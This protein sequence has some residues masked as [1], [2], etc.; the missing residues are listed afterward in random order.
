[1]NCARIVRIGRNAVMDANFWQERWRNDQ[2]AFHQHDFNPHLVKHW[3]ELGAD[4]GDRVFVP[5]CGKSRDMIWLAEQGHTVV[6]CEISEI[7]VE[8]FFVEASL[9]PRRTSDGPFE[10][11][12]A[13][14]I[15]ILLG[16]FF[17]LSRELIGEFGAVYDRASLV[18]FPETM[19][20]KYVQA[21]AKLTTRGT[22]MLLITLEYPQHEM[23]GPP[24]S[25]PEPKIRDLFSGVA[26]VEMLE[27]IPDALKDSARFST[28]GLSTLTEKVFRLQRS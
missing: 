8:S 1:M 19:R 4:P 2:I 15:E 22:S 28:W 25:L 27:W 24:F 5:L 11:W 18:A 10:R 17:S 20:P 14:S 26:E 12:S 7:A 6:G 16:D 9:V 13:E 3:Q 21:L 23:D